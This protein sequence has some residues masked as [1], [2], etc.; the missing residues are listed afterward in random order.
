MFRVQALGFG[1]AKQNHPFKGQ[2]LP[3]NVFLSFGIRVCQFFL[4][5]WLL[6]TVTT[7]R[8]SCLPTSL[9]GIGFFLRVSGLPPR[10]F[11]CSKQHCSNI[12]S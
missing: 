8:V 4:K 5:V 1:C 10:M 6:P 3:A 9:F 12:F 11:R 7:L 2:C